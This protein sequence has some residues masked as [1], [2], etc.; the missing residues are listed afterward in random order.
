[1]LVDGALRDLKPSDFKALGEIK[2]ECT[3]V[4]PT[5]TLTA[6]R[7]DDGALTLSPRDKVLPE[8]VLKGRA[9]SNRV[10]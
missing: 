4:R 2:V 6:G 9:I 1:M 8:K 10:S 7:S 3:L 5:G